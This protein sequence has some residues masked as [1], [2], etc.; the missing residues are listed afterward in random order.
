M[1]LESIVSRFLRSPVQ[2]IKQERTLIKFLI[3]GGSGAIVNLLISFYLHFL[4]AAELAQALGIELSIINNFVWNDS[5]TFRHVVQKSYSERSQKSRC[6]RLLKYNALSLGT[7]GLNLVVF[8]LLVY[9]LGWNHGIWYLASSLGAI[10]ASFA[11]N[12][13]GS[14]R[15]AWRSST[16]VKESQAQ[17]SV[18]SI[19]Q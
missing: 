15:W 2:T 1:P 12:Y 16:T 9:D 14:S 19:N 8:Y 11:L 18:P 17:K 6:Y 3:V 10:L 13:L 7:A 4:I 5:F